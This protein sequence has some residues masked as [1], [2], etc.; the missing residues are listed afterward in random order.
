MA[1][2]KE[3]HDARRHATA[4]G[5]HQISTGRH[6][7]AAHSP[8]TSAEPALEVPPSSTDDHAVDAEAGAFDPDAPS[9]GQP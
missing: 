8:G 3:Q 1:T 4:T 6:P 2:P 7:G 5:S 9:G